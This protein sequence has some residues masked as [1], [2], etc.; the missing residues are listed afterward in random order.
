[1]A[2]PNFYSHFHFHVDAFFL[3]RYPLRHESDLARTY[4][5]GQ[6]HYPGIWHDQGPREYHQT[7]A[8]SLMPGVLEQQIHPLH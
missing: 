2:S 7:Q 4:S 5:R 8:G 1:M 6:A 3:L